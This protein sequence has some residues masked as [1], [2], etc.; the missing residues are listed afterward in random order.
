[1]RRREFIALVAGAT[2]WPLVVR[3]QQP[4]K[5]PTIGILIPGSH[6]G[7]DQRVS[8]SV[9][10]LQELGWIDGRT[11]T[12]DYRWAEDQ[13]FDQI[14]ADF[15]RRKV[16]VVLTGGTPPVLA[17]RNA[18]SDIPIVLAAAGDPVGSGL[19]ASLARP[20]GNITGV[21]VQSRDIAG[22]RLSL[23]RE[24]VP[25]L[26]RL[27]IMGKIDNVSAASEMR[28]AQ[29][30]AGA[31]GLKSVSFE[32][33]SAEDIATSFDGIKDRADAL[34]VAVD[35]LVTTRGRQIATLAVA[36]KLPTMHG[37]EELV[38]AGGLMSYGANYLDV[39]RRAADK[40]DKIL[41]GAKPAE[42]PV[43]QPTKFDLVINRTTA[44]ALGL[45]I[46]PSLLATADQVIE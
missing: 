18:T 35:S 20:G 5:L 30:V 3:A 22:K 28:D 43:E 6:A 25:E 16:D 46:P 37:A 7:Y 9:Q 21:S 32:I 4:A 2:A 24:I 27:G 14:A 44:K 39:W 38:E 42:L 36:A 17:V 10:R 23:L 19:V 12:I 41:H 8:A 11:I 29:A 26:H 40:I 1:M 31:M 13:S 33:R 15:V 34:Y 45:T